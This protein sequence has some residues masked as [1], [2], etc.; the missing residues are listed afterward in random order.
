ML[1]C[2]L[3]KSDESTFFVLNVDW[4]FV[5][6]WVLPYINENAKR[7]DASILI[8]LVQVKVSVKENEVPTEKNSSRASIFATKAS[9]I[10]N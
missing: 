2:N 4:I 3:T 5:R 7:S 10:S 8:H 9:Y 6:H 1:Q